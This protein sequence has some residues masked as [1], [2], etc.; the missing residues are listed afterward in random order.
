MRTHTRIPCVMLDRVNWL[1]RCNEC[2]INYEI[3]IF[4]KF[5]LMLASLSKKQKV[6]RMVKTVILMAKYCCE[7]CF[8][9]NNPESY[10][11]L[12]EPLKCCFMSS[13]LRKACFLDLLCLLFTTLPKNLTAHIQHSLFDFS[14][15]HIYS[16]YILPSYFC[17]P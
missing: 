4:L 11:S 16:P 12:S 14:T 17:I 10:A 7:S 6:T 5:I 13:Q 3:F 2:T 9:E 8:K 15:Q 1:R